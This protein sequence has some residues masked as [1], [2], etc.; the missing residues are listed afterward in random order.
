MIDAPTK[1]LTLRS[2]LHL[3]QLTSARDLWYQSGG[4]YDNK[5]FGYTG[6]PANNHSSFA[7]LYDLSADYAVSKQLSLTAYYAHVFG[8]RVVQ[9]IYPVSGTSQYGYMELNWRFNR[10]FGGAP[11]S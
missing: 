6:R 4:A 11:P 8:K 9:A 10:P 5:V 3:L 1:K 7:T 2:D